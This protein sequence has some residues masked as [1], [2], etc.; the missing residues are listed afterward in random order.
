MNPKP[1]TRKKCTKKS[2]YREGRK[3]IIAPLPFA[4]VTDFAASVA[5]A[6]SCRI[7][8]LNVVKRPLFIKSCGSL[9]PARLLAASGQ[10]HLSL[11]V[12]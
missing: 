12:Q 3:R 5:D 6:P 8:S 10:D 1:N 2:N 11:N 4:L 9:C 7:D